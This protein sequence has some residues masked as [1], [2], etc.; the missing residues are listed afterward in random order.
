[1]KYRIRVWD[2]RPTGYFATAFAWVHL[3]R[4]VDGRWVRMKGT[5]TLTHDTGRVALRVRYQGHHKRMR[6]RSVAEKA[7]TFSRSES[8]VVRLW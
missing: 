7:P 8:P 2:E 6:V 5:R 4:K 1:V 3:E